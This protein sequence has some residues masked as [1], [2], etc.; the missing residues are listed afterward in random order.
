M[1]RQNSWQQSGSHP[2]N[3]PNEQSVYGDGQTKTSGG[4]VLELPGVCPT[5][6]LPPPR[7]IK[8][9]GNNNNQP[10][11]RSCGATKK[12]CLFHNFVV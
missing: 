7:N 12:G 11:R 2:V 6:T 10:C 4:G 5:N 8:K 1:L 3:E 9:K